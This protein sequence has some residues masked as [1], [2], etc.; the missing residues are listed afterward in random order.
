MVLI[1]KTKCYNSKSVQLPYGF[2]IYH[3][4]HLARQIGVNMLTCENTCKELPAK[5]I[6]CQLCTIQMVGP[7]FDSLL[8]KVCSSKYN[9]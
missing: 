3:P 8:L 9:S 1:D 5:H 2:Y 6:H 4:I 7:M